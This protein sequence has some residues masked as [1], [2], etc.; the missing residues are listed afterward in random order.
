M[1]RSRMS[2]LDNNSRCPCLEETGVATCEVKLEVLKLIRPYR[3]LGIEPFFFCSAAIF[4]LG[5]GS[6][7]APVQAALVVLYMASGTAIFYIMKAYNRRP[8]RRG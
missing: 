1:S 6:F 4:L 5:R 3:I 8:V 2:N 7:E